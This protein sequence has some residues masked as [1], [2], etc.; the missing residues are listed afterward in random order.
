MTRRFLPFLMLAVVVA[1]APSAM[2]ACWKCN[3]RNPPQC[4][5]AGSGVLGATYCENGVGDE[6]C[7]YWGSFCYGGQSAAP[8]PFS[9]EFTV[10]A[11]ERLD[12][13]QPSASET[14]VATIAVPRAT[15]Q[16]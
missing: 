2:A 16:R 15:S 11:V 12:E 10:A 1:N 6:P 13:A 3:P 14:L 5:L 4:I 8:E 7:I 9:A